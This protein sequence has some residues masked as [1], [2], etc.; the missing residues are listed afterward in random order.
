MTSAWRECENTSGFVYYVSMTG[1]TGAAI[2]DRAA[3][4][5]AVKRIKTHTDLPVAV[6]FGIKTA[7]DAA[8]I[9]RDA[10]GVVVGTVLCNA[11]GQSLENKKATPGTVAAVTTMVGGLAAG[12]RDR[13]GVK[14]AGW[15]AL[16][17]GI[18]FMS[19]TALMMWI[20]PHA[21]VGLFV[22]EVPENARVI[23]LAVAFLGLEHHRSGSIAEQDAGRTVFPVEDSAEGLGTDH[24]RGSA[25][26]GADHRIGDADRIEEV[27]QTA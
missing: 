3:V 14:R 18:S 8:T 15:V 27:V 22:E 2:K 10:D 19:F 26:S 23:E 9:G 4:G 16:A 5:D 21:L 13:E 20:M 12:A 7:E 25:G 1:I 11:V 24:Q 17:L 6:G